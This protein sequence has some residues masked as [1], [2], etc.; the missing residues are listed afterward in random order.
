LRVRKNHRFRTFKAT[1]VA[2]YHRLGGLPQLES[3]HKFC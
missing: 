3:T 2:P 1:E